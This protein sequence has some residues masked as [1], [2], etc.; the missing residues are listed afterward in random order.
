MPLNKTNVD[1]Q[2]ER[3]LSSAH[4]LQVLGPIVKRTKGCQWGCSGIS[5]DLGTKSSLGPD[6]YFTGGLIYSQNP[7][8][9]Y[10]LLVPPMPL[11]V[12]LAYRQ[13]VCISTLPHPLY[14]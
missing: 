7:T 8:L 14:S 12:A 6:F 10:M 11:T 3:G 13:V 9:G 4:A 5:C 2:D 1:V